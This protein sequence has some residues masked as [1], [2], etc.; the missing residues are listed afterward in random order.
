MTG[1]EALVLALAKVNINSDIDTDNLDDDYV[2]SLKLT[3][4]DGTIIE[5][6]PELDFPDE[7]NMEVIIVRDCTGRR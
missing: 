3:F 2:A 7:P 4:P 1:I 5:L 6:L